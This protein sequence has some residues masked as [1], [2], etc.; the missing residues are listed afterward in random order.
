MPDVSKGAFQFAKPIHTLIALSLHNH[1]VWDIG[2]YP[3]LIGE[4]TEAPQSQV[5][6]PQ[7]H[8]C[9]VMN[10]HPLL[11]LR[12]P[13]Q[14]A[15]VWRFR[16]PSCQ[17]LSIISPPSSCRGLGRAPVSNRLLYSPAIILLPPPGP[18]TSKKAHDGGLELSQ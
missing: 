10:R 17:S 16:R 14:D 9:K 6:C 8:G 11:H 3:H 1:F 15:V 7:T 2:N 12:H 13:S 4:E 18:A 5:V